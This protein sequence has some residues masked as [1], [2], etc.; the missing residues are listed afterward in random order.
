MN[1]RKTN[2]TTQKEMLFSLNKYSG[3][4]SKITPQIISIKY[5]HTSLL[6][7]SIDKEMCVNKDNQCHG[8]FQTFC[9]RISILRN[10]M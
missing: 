6:N 8:D 9:R 3:K 5:E 2:Q 4:R 1:E 10:E 7:S